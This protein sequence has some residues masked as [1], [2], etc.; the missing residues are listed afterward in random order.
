MSGQQ[1]Q[2]NVYR[3]EGY[4]LEN[5]MHF[6][7]GKVNRETLYGEAYNSTGRNKVRHPGQAQSNGK[8]LD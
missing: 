6:R 2:A 3:K 4:R 1:D 5:R 8:H 7:W